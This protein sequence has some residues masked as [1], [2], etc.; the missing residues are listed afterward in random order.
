MNSLRMLSLSAAVIVVALTTAPIAST[1]T[2]T[3]Y[4]V[5]R[6][7]LRA[8]PN[9]NARVVAT[10]PPRDSVQAGEGACRGMWCRVDYNGRVGYAA[11]QFLTGFPQCIGMSPRASSQPPQGRSP[12]SR[13]YI[14]NWLNARRRE[15]ANIS[16]PRLGTEGER[17]RRVRE[18]T[19]DY[20]HIHLGELAGREEHFC[21]PYAAVKRLHSVSTGRGEQYTITLF[22]EWL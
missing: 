7:R 8:Q 9:L 4:A 12:Y 15:G 5:A 10:I 1:Q 21:V 17:N 20:F 14:Q 16:V 22:D 11:E 13:A 2:S 3:L 19:A 6:L 18:V